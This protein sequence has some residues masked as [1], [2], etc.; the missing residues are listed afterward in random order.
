MTSTDLQPPA[1]R[2]ARPGPMRQCALTRARAPKSALL[3]VVL[4]ET[5]HPMFDL[6]A[7]APGRGVYVVP[8][9]E[10]VLRA[11]APAGLGRL[12]RG[13]AR[14]LA[15]DAARALVD[16]TAERLRERLAAHLRF[17]RRAGHIVWGVGEV[18]GAK[19]PV[20]LVVVAEDAS[21][22]SQARL[23]GLDPEH[24]VRRVWGSK[25][26]LGEILGKSEVGALGVRRSVFVERILWDGDRL[27]RLTD[28]ARSLEGPARTEEH[29]DS[30]SHGE[31]TD[32]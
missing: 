23:E 31:E 6:L 1:G 21:P 2:A 29:D 3:R 26:R 14:P 32:L 7:R 5:G 11:L 24:T 19:P 25:Q 4:D 16:A 30:R 15:P 27:R 17:A 18:E 13:A 22:R 10:V 28:G 12:F 8:D 9:R 20:A